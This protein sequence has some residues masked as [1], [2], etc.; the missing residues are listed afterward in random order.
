MTQCKCK[1]SLLNSYDL[2][3]KFLLT[4]LQ[5]SIDTSTLRGSK[6]NTEDSI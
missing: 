5:T 2:L 3:V 6:Y 1:S 4:N